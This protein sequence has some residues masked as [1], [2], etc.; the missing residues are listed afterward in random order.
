M[1]FCGECG[2]KIETEAAC[3]SC[4]HVNK[5]GVKFCSECGQT[6]GGAKAAQS[7]ALKTDKASYFYGEDLA[8]SVTGITAAMKKDDAFVGIYQAGAGHNQYKDYQYPNFGDSTVYFSVNMENGQYEVRLYS[9]DGTYDDTTFVT[10]VAFSVVEEPD[11]SNPTIALD[12]SSYNYG[13]NINVA[14]K[15]VSQKMVRKSACATI[16]RKGADHDEAENR[17]GL[18]EGDNDIIFR[19][20]EVGEYEV[21]LYRGQCS[22]STFG[23]KIPFTAAGHEPVPVYCAVCGFENA[24]GTKFCNNCGSKVSTGKCSACG[25]SNDPNLKFCGGCGGKL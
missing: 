25:A 18:D 14:V 6:I 2:G 1:R 5:A 16:H 3:S 13:D 21:R 20:P 11:D 7:T 10:K 8:V 23:M 19:C 12:G 4:G 22:A 24:E 15:G 9:R 17:Y